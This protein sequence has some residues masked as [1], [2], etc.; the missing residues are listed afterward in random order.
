VQNA[1]V[2]M[3]MHMITLR[4]WLLPPASKSVEFSLFPIDIPAQVSRAHVTVKD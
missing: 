3:R 2:E 4:Q 1:L